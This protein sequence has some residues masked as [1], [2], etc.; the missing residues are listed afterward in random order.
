ML[1]TVLI[2]QEHGW[3]KDNMIHPSIFN[4]LLPGVHLKSYLYNFEALR[5][6]TYWRVT[7]KRGRHL[8]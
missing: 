7:L 3:T 8:N 2:K 1:S 6:S 4:L 5:G